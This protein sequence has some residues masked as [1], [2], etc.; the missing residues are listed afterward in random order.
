MPEPTNER[1][2]HLTIVEFIKRL[3]QEPS[4]FLLEGDF[5]W[6]VADLLKETACPT[7]HDV[8]A[9]AWKDLWESVLEGTGYSDKE[10]KEYEQGVI[11]VLKAKKATAEEKNLIPKLAQRTCD[12]DWMDE[13]T[14]LAVMTSGCLYLFELLEMEEERLAL[15]GDN[16]PIV[17]AALA[18]QGLSVGRVFETELRNKIIAAAN[19]NHGLPLRTRQRQTFD[20]GFAHKDQT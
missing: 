9:E 6:I 20:A 19:E 4:E 14:S 5:H 7:G 16:A 10:Y 12:L 18:S 13:P 15:F 3:K 11:A 2:Y 8:I 1:P 17:K